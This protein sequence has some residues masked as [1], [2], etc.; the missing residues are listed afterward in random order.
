MFTKLNDFLQTERA[1]NLL[2]RFLLEV[3]EMLRAV[4]SVQ[5]WHCS[6]RLGLRHRNWVHS[7][8]PA[9]LWA[10]PLCT[11]CLLLAWSWAGSCGGWLAR[12]LLRLLSI[13]YP[14]GWAWPSRANPGVVCEPLGHFCILLFTTAGLLLKEYWMSS[15]SNVPDFVHAG[16]AGLWEVT[17]KTTDSCACVPGD[18]WE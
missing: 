11:C 8:E 5:G 9:A 17:I 15:M 14:K 13:L 10:W 6:Q 2:K 7:E 18:C 12:V 4:Q 3:L 1:C 16:V